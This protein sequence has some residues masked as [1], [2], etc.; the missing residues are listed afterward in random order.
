[1]NKIIHKFA[2]L[3]STPS[4]V[5]PHKTNYEATCS[6]GLKLGPY[7]S[8]DDVR[9]EF[10]YHISEMDCKKTVIKN[11]DWGQWF[12]QWDA[13]CYS[14]H[15]AYSDDQTDS[16]VLGSIVGHQQKLMKVIPPGTRDN[17]KTIL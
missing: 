8:A 12:I 6:C 7:T 4:C 2:L 1:M 9:S 11:L 17:D 3:S 16:T 15:K 14:F 10:D 5:I 13:A